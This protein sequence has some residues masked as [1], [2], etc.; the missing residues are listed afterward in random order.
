VTITTGLLLVLFALTALMCTAFVSPGHP[1]NPPHPFDADDDGIEHAGRHE[2][3]DDGETR[4][5][6][7]P[8]PPTHPR[9]I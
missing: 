2:R 5:L 8:A 6:A 9:D 1:V 3:P 4:R 7:P